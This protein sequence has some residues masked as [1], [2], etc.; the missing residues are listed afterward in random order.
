MKKYEKDGMVA[1]LV[2]PGYGAGWST[3]N[4]SKYCEIL[5]MDYDVVEAFI[6]GNLFK[7]KSIVE[8]KVGGGGIYFGGLEDVV[9][10]WVEKGTAFEITEYDGSE[11][12]RIINNIDFM[13]A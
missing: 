10:K 8:E 6:E 2:S 4:D 5:T 13:V 1:V 11:S 3:W 9:V 12:I 7:V